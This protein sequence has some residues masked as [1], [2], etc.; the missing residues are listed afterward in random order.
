MTHVLDRAPKLGPVIGSTAGI[1]EPAPKAAAI[2]RDAA[3]LIDSSIR[4]DTPYELP[5]ISLP[6]MSYW[7]MDLR[8]RLQFKAGP[9]TGT[10]GDLAL[11][12]LTANDAAV[13]ERIAD[14]LNYLHGERLKGK[15]TKGRPASCSGR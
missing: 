7:L 13:L 12:T 2:V 15:W 9:L 4:P 8:L 14:S 10:D 1:E 11:V 6:D 5:K 3:A